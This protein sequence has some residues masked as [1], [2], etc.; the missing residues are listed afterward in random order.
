MEIRHPV[1]NIKNVQNFLQHVGRGFV[2]PALDAFLKYVLGNERHGLRHYPPQKYV[3]RARAGYKTSP[4]Q[5]RFFFATGIL[6]NVGGKIKLNRYKRTFETQKAWQIVGQGT[7]RP[8][9]V[10]SRAYY[11]MDDKGQARQPAL[12][13]WRKVSQV[14]RDNLKG[15]IN[16]AASAI[17]KVIRS[18]AKA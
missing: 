12:V 14:V 9:L 18:K 15:A 17:N 5:I 13:G 11:T 2:L 8:S 10:N 7:Y 6:E 16:S 1:R 4:A 3:S